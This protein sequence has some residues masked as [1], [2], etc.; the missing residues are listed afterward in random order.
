MALGRTVICRILLPTDQLLGTEKV[1]VNA[2]ANLI[3]RLRDAFSRS[4]YISPSPITYRGV[5]IDEDG[6]WDI[7][8]SIGL[9]EE[10]LVRA[11]PRSLIGYHRINAAIGLQ[12]MFE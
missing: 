3:D 9:S 7:F 2:R 8:A 12:T 5:K 1:T 11:A 10:S 4:F 6:S